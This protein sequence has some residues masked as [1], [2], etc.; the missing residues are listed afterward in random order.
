M[1]IAEAICTPFK[2]SL[3]DREPAL[4]LTY[5]SEPALDLTY[6]S[7]PAL[8]LAYLSEPALE[9]SSLQDP[10]KFICNILQYNE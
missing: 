1:K 9:K 8:D 10:I 6:L 2:W 7:E 5:L 4:D 3:L